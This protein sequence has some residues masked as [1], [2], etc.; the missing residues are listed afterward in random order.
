[1]NTD[2]NK[3]IELV[4]KYMNLIDEE[5]EHGDYHAPDLIPYEHEDDEDY[6]GDHDKIVNDVE[7]CRSKITEVIEK[8]RNAG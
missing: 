6:Y 3:L 7:K 8:I 4:E 2:T 1:M 5:M